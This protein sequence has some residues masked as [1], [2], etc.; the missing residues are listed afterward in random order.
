MS[1]AAPNGLQPGNILRDPHFYL[2]TGTGEFKPK[3][4]VVLAITRG[5]DVVWRLLTSQHAELRPE[6]PRCHHGNPYP[7]FYLGVLDPSI[8]LGKKSWLDLRGLE[9]AD[10][11][12]LVKSVVA[13]TVTVVGVLAADILRAAMECAAG[14]NDTTQAQERAIRDQLAAL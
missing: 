11:I 8:G 9:D 12:E 5:K 7:G 1:G 2:D 13:G 14:A 6:M 3:F 4:I 10:G